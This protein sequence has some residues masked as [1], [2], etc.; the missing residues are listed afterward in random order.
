[1][2]TVITISRQFGSGGRLIGKLLAQKLSIP[3]YDK[4]IIFK[5]AD[6]S[7]LASTQEIEVSIYVNLRPA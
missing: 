3:Y 7:G 4:E 6:K 1:M 2:N 5:A